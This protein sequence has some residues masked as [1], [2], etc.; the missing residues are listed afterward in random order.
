[1]ATTCNDWEQTFF[2]ALAR[3]F[4]FGVNNDAFEHWAKVDEGHDCI[5]FV[6]AWHTTE[7]EVTALLALLQ[8]MLG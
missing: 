1:L 5:R 8:K 6:T 3:N 4:G 2:I 7:E